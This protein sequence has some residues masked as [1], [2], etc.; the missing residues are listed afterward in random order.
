[1]LSTST[2][3]SGDGSQS[4]GRGPEARARQTSAGRRSLSVWTTI[5]R[6]CRFGSGMAVTAT[7]GASEILQH[8]GL[9]QGR[10]HPF[11]GHHLARDLREPAEAPVIHRN[12]SASTWPRSPVAYQ[13]SLTAFA[14][15][16]G[17]FR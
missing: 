5:K 6:S 17:R 12:P 8:G 14:V 2:K 15:A 9:D 1:M 4:F 16:S 11:M 13:P 3:S 10:L 7:A